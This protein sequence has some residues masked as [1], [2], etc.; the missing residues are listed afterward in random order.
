MSAYSQE[1]LYQAR[2]A[3]A[4]TLSKSE[5]VL[6]KLR[7]GTGQHTM[8]SAGIRAYQIAIALIE[9]EAGAAV[10]GAYARDEL[11][12][13]LET[14]ALARRRVEN[15]LPKFKPGTPQHTLAVRRIAAFQIAEE[16]MR[17]AETQHE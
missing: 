17:W 12:A 9:Q 2:R 10:E 6:T 15:I 8:T 11:N 5:K 14:I 4:S 16:R 7:E 3:I 1:D 13:A